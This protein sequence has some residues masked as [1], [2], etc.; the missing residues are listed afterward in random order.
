MGE[1]L[2]LRWTLPLFDDLASDWN[3]IQSFS[4]EKEI[5]CWEWF[6]DTVDGWSPD[7]ISLLQP[8]GMVEIVGSI[9]SCI[10]HT[11]NDYDTE[12]KRYTGIFNFCGDDLDG[13][14]LL[15]FSDC[16]CL[17]SA[18]RLDETETLYSKRT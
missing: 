17:E 1:W 4:E 7:T 5:V 14:L 6:L 3:E 2:K 13:T 11:Q 15:Y 9:P 16:G 8:N 10:S 12:C 18:A